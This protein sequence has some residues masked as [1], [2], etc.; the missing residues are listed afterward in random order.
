MALTNDRLRSIRQVNFER[1]VFQHVQWQCD[2]HLAGLNVTPRSGNGYARIRLS[3]DLDRPIEVHRGGNAFTDRHRQCLRSAD[4]SVLRCAKSLLDPTKCG[5]FMK[6]VDQAV[7][8]GMSPLQSKAVRQNQPFTRLIELT[9]PQVRCHGH[10]KF[11]HSRVPSRIGWVHL[12]RDRFKLAQHRDRLSRKALQYRITA[13]LR[14]RLE[15]N[16]IASEFFHQG[17]MVRGCDPFSA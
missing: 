11:P 15:P 3:D 10:V 17:N 2:N 7:V 4:Y 16:A 13:L 5:K 12:F 14:R 9:G 8:I 1:Q 6:Q